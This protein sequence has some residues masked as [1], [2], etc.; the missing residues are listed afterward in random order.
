[1]PTNPRIN[2]RV[3]VLV[4]ETNRVIGHETS[5]VCDCKRGRVAL[6]SA[7]NL[8]VAHVRIELGDCE[9]RNTGNTPNLCKIRKR[10]ATLK[11][12]PG[13]Q[14]YPGWHLPRVWS[15]DR[16]NMHSSSSSANN[17]IGFSRYMSYQWKRTTKN[18]WSHPKY[19]A[20]NQ[21][22]IRGKGTSH[23]YENIPEGVCCRRRWC[24]PHQHPRACTPRVQ[25]GRCS[26]QIKSTRKL[27]SS[28]G[29]NTTTWRK[30]KL[31][32][33]SKEYARWQHHWSHSLDS[34]LVEEEL[35]LFIG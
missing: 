10:G 32:Y 6:Q 25:S 5:I 17:P 8:L 19:R 35:K 31:S 29:G 33:S 16:G 20:W 4:E 30:S 3:L 11:Q 28:G 21:V 7:I 9:W 26:A 24:L 34:Y 27:S 14:S 13:T 23:E 22:A 18:C 12:T 15:V 1:M 2:I